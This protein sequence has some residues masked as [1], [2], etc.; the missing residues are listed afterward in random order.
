MAKGK[1]LRNSV[2]SEIKRISIAP[3][4]TKKE[5]EENNRLLD[6]LS[7][8]RA[9]GGKWIIRRGKLVRLHSEE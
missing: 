4:L 3:D 7:E 5:R 2:G 1:Q 9:Q 6:E 8:R